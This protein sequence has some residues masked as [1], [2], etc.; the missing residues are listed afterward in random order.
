MRDIYTALFKGTILPVYDAKRASNVD[1]MGG[2]PNSVPPKC[3]GD[4]VAEIFGISRDRDADQYLSFYL[5][6]L[7]LIRGAVNGRG[8]QKS[9]WAQIGRAH[10]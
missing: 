10:V 7:A 4:E 6:T 5:M 9:D 1:G 2:D 3:S 8:D